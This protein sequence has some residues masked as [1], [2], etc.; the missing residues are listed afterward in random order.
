MPTSY[1]PVSK[2][3]IVIAVVVLMI[4]AGALGAR[5]FLNRLA[6]PSVDNLTAILPADNTAVIVVR[7]LP[8]LALDFG[9]KDVLRRASEQS[10]ELKKRLDEARQAL[11]F[12]LADPDSVT[13]AGIDP[14]APLAF[15]IRFTGEGKPRLAAYLPASSPESLEGRLRQAA[16]DRGKAIESFDFEGVQLSGTA[17]RSIQYAFRDS[18]LVLTA[19]S[20]GEDLSRYLKGLVTPGGGAIKDTPWYKGQAPLVA[21]SD[22]KFLLL[23]SSE[24]FTAAT[25]HLQNLDASN[26][27]L[28]LQTRQFQDLESLGVALDLTPDALTVRSRTTARPDA[29]HPLD[30]AIGQPEDRLVQMV[31]GKAF[32]AMRAAIDA[33]RAVGQL[34]EQVPEM[35]GILGEADQMLT[36]TVGYDL[37]KGI[38]PFLSSPLSLA[39]L[40]DQGPMPVGA[41]LWWPVKEGHH[42]DEILSKLHEQFSQ[43]TVPVSVETQGTTLW[44]TVTAGPVAGRLGV[45]R[46]HLVVGVGQ[47]TSPALAKALETPQGSFLDAISQSNV[48]EGLKTRGDSFM[49]L[50]FPAVYAT[51]KK[52]AGE[53]KVPAEIDPLLSS[54]GPLW[55]SNETSARE[56]DGELVWNAARPRAFATAFDAI[57][58]LAAR[59]LPRLEEA[60]AELGGGGSEEVVAEEPAVADD[61]EVDDQP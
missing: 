25:A 33:Q 9:L 14:L 5:M 35:G 40:E 34:T 29:K 44:Y 28:G 2:T 60:A 56:A 18:Y 39:V 36:G 48:R 22:W 37:Q 3:P 21:A 24:L 27:F 45:A 7:G 26:P 15:T 19:G 8:R 58:M 10:P 30:T 31:P 54:L 55:A 17:D 57:V 46:D 43:G 32:L 13:A 50:D 61:G 42:F 38:L 16:E 51:V 20:G 6:S 4:A 11:G 49:Y 52:V 47:G 41:A 1:K 53:G 23:M 12:D 59:E